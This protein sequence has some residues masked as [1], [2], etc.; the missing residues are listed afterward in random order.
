MISRRLESSLDVYTISTWVRTNLRKANHDM[1]WAITLGETLNC[2]NA[3]NSILTTPTLNRYVRGFLTKKD[4]SVSDQISR[5]TLSGITF[6]SL[7]IQL[8]S[9]YFPNF[10]QFLKV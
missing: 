9:Q 1:F 7:R 3:V 6:M 5:G 2:E 10:Y 4:D 8:Q